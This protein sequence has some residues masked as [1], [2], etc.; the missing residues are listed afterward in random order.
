MAVCGARASKVS[1][2]IL[3]MECSKPTV[4]NRDRAQKIMISLPASDFIFVAHHTVR[5]TNMLHRAPRKSK[6]RKGTLTLVAT[7]VAMA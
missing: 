1:K 2:V 7:A 5:Q 6:G 4:K 3:A